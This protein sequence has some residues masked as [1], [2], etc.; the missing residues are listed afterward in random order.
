MIVLT[1]TSPR[2]LLIAFMRTAR[3]MLVSSSRTALN[4]PERNAG[5]LMTTSISSAPR[6]TA[7]SAANTLVRA[8]SAPNGNE[9]T[10]HTLTSAPR[11]RSAARPVNW[12]NRQTA[13]KW[14]LFAS[15]QSRCASCDVPSARSMV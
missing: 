10:V 3:T 14:Y 9:I 8:V 6:A 11:S 4:S 7:S 1:T 2:P 13:A 15:R 5:R 12:G